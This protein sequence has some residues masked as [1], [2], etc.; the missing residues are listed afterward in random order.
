MNKRLKK[1]YSA[2][3]REQFGSLGA[4]VP[5]GECWKIEKSWERV[6]DQITIEEFIEVYYHYNYTGK[7]KRGYAKLKNQFIKLGNIF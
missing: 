1:K 5:L 6:Q 7:M 4:V 2:K 3:I